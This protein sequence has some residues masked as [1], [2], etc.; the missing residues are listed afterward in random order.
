MPNDSLF[1]L[2]V[3][4]LSVAAPARAAAPSL[5]T[6]TAAQQ[7]EVKEAIARLKASDEHVEPLRQQPDVSDCQTV[8]TSD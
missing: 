2:L 6:A 3:T 1:A 4:V 8:L 7:G 5:V